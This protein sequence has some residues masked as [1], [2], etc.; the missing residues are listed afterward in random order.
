[1]SQHCLSFSG[2]IVL[3]D[4]TDPWLSGIHGDTWSLTGDGNIPFAVTDQGDIARYTARAAILAFNDPE[5]IPR[6]LRVYSDLK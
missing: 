5:S 1:M 3:T 4:I 2:W 6:R